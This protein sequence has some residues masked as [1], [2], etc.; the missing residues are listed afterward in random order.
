MNDDRTVITSRKVI[1]SRQPRSS[2]TKG[3]RRRLK[4]E[5]GSPWR[6]RVYRKATVT[7]TRS[8]PW[9]VPR[10]SPPVNP[11]VMKLNEA[12]RALHPCSWKW[13]IT[14]GPWK[15]RRP[16]ITRSSR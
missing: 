1:R 11:P 14:G 10:R 4:A 8:A 9:R 16:T 3:R 12:W 5:D 7:S 15:H 2:S 13:V 6:E